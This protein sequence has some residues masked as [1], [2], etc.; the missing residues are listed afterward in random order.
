MDR[1]IWATWYD[2]PEQGRDEH[3]EWLHSVYLPAML[4]RPGYLWAAHVQNVTSPEREAQIDGRLSHVSD[5]GVPDGFAY[6][7]LFGSAN[8]HVFVD[9]SPA[10]LLAGLDAESRSMLGQRQGERSCIF[11]EVSRVDGRQAS[12]RRPGITPGPV[13][14]F[15][16][17]NIK[18]SE[19]ET[20]MN[21][22]YARSRFELVRPV[23]GNVG[24][25]RLVSIAG[26]AKH[27]VLYEFTSL[28]AA[29]KNLADGSD[30]SRQVVSTLL[31]APHSPTLGVRIWP[32]S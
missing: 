28:E 27:A 13:I 4:S 18:A 17:F 29:G 1:G 8:P 22:W 26:W 25:R 11:V 32:P 16:S 2:L 23:D 10:E 21:T 9:P 3:I 12:S 19:H 7:V 24:V 15:G 31:H 6:L 30:W 20:A 14:Q 5:P